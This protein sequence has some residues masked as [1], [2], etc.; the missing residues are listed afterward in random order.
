LAATDTM[1]QLRVEDERLVLEEAPEWLDEDA[2][3]LQDVAREGEQEEKNI[4]LP[5]QTFLE[6]EIKG[7]LEPPPGHKTF[8][9]HSSFHFNA[10][11]FHLNPSTHCF[12]R[13]SGYLCP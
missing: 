6:E 1:A 9:F 10:K 7:E 4:P 3:V 2:N 12:Q 11:T 13:K 8:H 5:V